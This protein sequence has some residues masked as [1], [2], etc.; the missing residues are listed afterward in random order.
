MTR[1]ANVRIV[2]LPFELQKIDL[3]MQWHTRMH[4]DPASKW[5]RDL[6]AMSYR[7]SQNGP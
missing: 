3:C 4:R 6:C 7:N 2:A 5:F 1:V